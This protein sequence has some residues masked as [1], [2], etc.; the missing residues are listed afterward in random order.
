MFPRLILGTIEG[1]GSSVCHGCSGEQEQNSSIPDGIWR[2][3]KSSIIDAWRPDHDQVQAMTSRTVSLEMG[4]N[5][6]AAP[7]CTWCDP[8]PNNCT[9]QNG[10]C[11]A[12]ILAVPIFE[13][14]HQPAK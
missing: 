12:M 5:K 10:P 9:E 13:G 8:A 1:F 7:S 14:E 11:A 4:Y 2:H 6:P 3:N